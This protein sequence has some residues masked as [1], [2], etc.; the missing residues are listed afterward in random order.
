MTQHRR[1]RR[2]KKNTTGIRGPPASLFIV[3]TT[4]PPAKSDAAPRA[5]GG[6]IKTATSV[7]STAVLLFLLLAISRYCF[8]SGVFLLS[9]LGVPF[10]F[11]IACQARIAVMLEHCCHAPQSRCVLLLTVQQSR[12]STMRVLRIFFHTLAISWTASSHLSSQPLALGLQSL[13]HVKPSS[14]PSMWCCYCYCYCYFL[15]LLLLLLPTSTALYF[16][17]FTAV[18][19]SFLPSFHIS[20]LSRIPSRSSVCSAELHGDPPK[21]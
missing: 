11:A 13:T 18:P 17:C 16:F 21:K 10:L 3:E 9:S 7:L 2:K 15:L 4:T 1:E 8:S 14:Q 5:E 12:R 6:G 19:P 20:S